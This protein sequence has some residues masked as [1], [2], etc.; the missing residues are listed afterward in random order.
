MYKSMYPYIIGINGQ[1]SSGKTRVTEMI[2]NSIEGITSLSMDNF[3]KGLN[4]VEKNNIENYNF[5]EPDALDLDLFMDC[6][7]RLKN[8]EDVEIPVYDFKTHSRTDEKMLVKPSK[9]IIAE[10]ILIFCT[11]ELR[12]IFDMKVYIDASISTVI[13]RRLERDLVERGRDFKSVKTQYKKFVDPAYEKYIRPMKKI[14]DIVIPNEDDNEFIG[15]KMLCEIIKCK[16][17]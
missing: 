15:V 8:G 16:M 17:E 4:E 1:T 12:K 11:E 13:F 2:K 10:G 6:I 7:K 9:I 14:C 3:Y 5:D